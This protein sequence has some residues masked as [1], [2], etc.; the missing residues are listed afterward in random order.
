MEK[1]SLTCGL[2][3]LNHQYA[4]IG[5]QNHND[6]VDFASASAALATP[7]VTVRIAA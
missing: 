5:A 4:L 3:V 2:V 1:C 7:V 6:V